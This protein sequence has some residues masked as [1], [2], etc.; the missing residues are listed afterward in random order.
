M[1]RE[2]LAGKEKN[3]VAL[4]LIA[5]M[6]VLGGLQFISYA[7]HEK[8]FMGDETYYYMRIA[9][10]SQESGVTNYDLLQDREISFN[11]F[12]LVPGVSIVPVEVAARL[13][14][15]IMGVLSAFLFYVL[16]K[17]FKFGKDERLIATIIF[18]ANPLFIHF[19]TSFTP[20]ILAVPLG[21]AGS[22]FL[23][24]KKKAWGTAFFAVIPLLSVAAAIVA[25]LGL[26]VF[27]LLDKK[28][29]LYGIASMI[30]MALVGVASWLFLGFSPGLELMPSQ[31]SVG[32]VFVE[33]GGVQAYSLIIFALAAMGIIATWK[34]NI[35]SISVF[36]LIVFSFGFSLL[37]PETRIFVGMIISVYAGIA[38]INVIRRE[39]SVEPIKNVTLLL[40][41]CS[42]V[43]SFVVSIDN[44]FSHVSADKINGVVYLSTAGHGDVVLSAERNGFMIGYLSGRKSFIDGFSYKYY[45]YD[46]RKG[47]ASSIYYS[48]DLRVLEETLRESNINHVLLD[49]EMRHGEIWTGSDE[50]ILFLFRHAPEFVRIFSNDEV[51]I[52]R[53]VR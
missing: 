10:Q 8:A 19:F 11:L 31:G 34:R 37:Y 30:A 41:L 5:T 44:A 53:Y 17:S 4:I 38:I 36:L 51:I 13:L 15:V 35:I 20:L 12:Y 9:K 29:R 47:I 6:L 33:L 27:V 22:I 1:K 24:R 7:V 52:Y 50:G 26:I 45:Y 46:E 49:Y 14:P 23:L 42:I 40:V 48:R 28:I 21:L 18:A 25:L 3:V 32:R 16:V 39:W 2:N 43:F